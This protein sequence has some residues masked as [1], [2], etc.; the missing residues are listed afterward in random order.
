MGPIP[1]RV[2]PDFLK[3]QRDGVTE[4]EEDAEV[5]PLMEGRPNRQGMPAPRPL[6]RIPSTS[7]I[8]DV[9][10]CHQSEYNY[11][12]Q[13]HIEGESET[14]PD[15]VFVLPPGT[16]RHPLGSLKGVSP[17][18]TQGEKPLHGDA[19]DDAGHFRGYDVDSEKEK[20]GRAHV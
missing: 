18:C 12:H 19:V 15:P 16:P 9:L 3:E 14:G 17:T 10:C 20:I 1:G 13:T 5:V 2:S 11:C 7:D 8:S 4:D 6:V